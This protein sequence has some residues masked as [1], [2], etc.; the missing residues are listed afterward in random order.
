MQIIVKEKDGIFKYLTPYN[1][2]FAEI[3]IKSRQEYQ[4]F[5]NNYWEGMDRQFFSLMSFREKKMLKRNFTYK[6]FLV[7]YYM[8]KIEALERLFLHPVEPTGVKLLEEK[9]FKNKISLRVL[10]DQHKDKHFMKFVL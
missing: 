8:D 3:I 5:V 9:I 10:H 6:E 7:L 4:D 1:I 2:L